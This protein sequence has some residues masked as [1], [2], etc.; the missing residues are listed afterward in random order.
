MVSKTTYSEFVLWC[1]TLLSKMWLPSRWS[2][3]VHWNTKL[4]TRSNTDTFWNQ[5]IN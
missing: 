5:P 1:S 3:Q 4:S 2:K